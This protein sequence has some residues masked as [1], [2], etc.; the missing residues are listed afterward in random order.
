MAGAQGC[1]LRVYR[2]AA[3]WQLERA[4][5]LEVK[6]PEGASSW[7]P[8][9]D[10]CL[11]PGRYAWTVRAEQREEQ[12]GEER[13]EQQEHSGGWSEAFGGGPA[14]AL[15][16]NV[17]DAAGE[18]YGFAL[19]ANTSGAN[20]VALGNS[21][22]GAN[23]SGASNVAIGQN[24]GSDLTTGNDNIAIGNS[25]VSAESGRIRIGT[26]GPHDATF[27]AGINGVT[28]AGGTAVFIKADGQLGTSTSSRRFKEEIA[29]LEGA[30][31]RLFALR[32]VSFRYTEEAAGRASGRSSTG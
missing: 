8:P 3:T 5:A 28:V 9:A 1:E 13:Q 26:N 30:S 21:A 24:A 6:L 19:D 2:I 32:P 12:V 25:G 15:L 10:A 29:D 16:G 27:I 7:T 22:L 11:A 20:N 18:T 14:T 23:T 4:A 17:P 31:E